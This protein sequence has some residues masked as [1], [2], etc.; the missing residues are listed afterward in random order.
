MGL[1]EII[2]AVGTA[3][4]LVMSLSTMNKQVVGLA[5]GLSVGVAIALLLPEYK[6]V[7][8]VVYAVFLVLTF[9]HALKVN[10]MSTK[11][12][13]MVASGAM[14]YYWIASILHLPGRLIIGPLL[15]LGALCFSLV[16]K[17]SKTHLGLIIIIMAD[18][19]AVVIEWAL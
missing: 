5:S 7:G 6:T 12:V 8:F 17:P 9:L 16:S 10:N 3:M 4:G 2:V 11:V 15:A 13:M 18:A 1:L 14:A 19:L